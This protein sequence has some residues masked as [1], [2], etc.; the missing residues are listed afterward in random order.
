MLIGYGCVY[1]TS[2]FF[3]P[4]FPSLNP[5]LSHL[6]SL[7]ATLLVNKKSNPQTPPSPS[8]LLHEPAT[9]TE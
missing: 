9:T 3:L 8:L 5:I 2:L 4:S 1:E 6:H 7:H